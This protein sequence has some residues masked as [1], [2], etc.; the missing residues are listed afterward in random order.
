[1]KRN[2]AILAALVTAIAV[3]LVA[4]PVAS[5]TPSCSDDLQLV[6]AST[7]GGGSGFL[8][9]TRPVGGFGAECDNVA[10]WSVKLQPQH[11][12]QSFWFNFDAQIQMPNQSCGTADHYNTTTAHH[13]VVEW[14]PAGDCADVEANNPSANHN[15]LAAA[16][17][18]TIFQGD[19]YRVVITFTNT[20]NGNVIGTDTTQIATAS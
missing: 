19:R 5:A 8:A 12:S 3:G 17:T 7:Q 11:E 14:F 10:H 9:I 1:M 4:A 15:D 20:D 13:L 18:G 6:A 16:T 2:L